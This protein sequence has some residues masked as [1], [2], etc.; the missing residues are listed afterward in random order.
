MATTIENLH[1][2]MLALRKD[3]AF[4]KHVLSEDFE[5]SEEASRGLRKARETPESEYVDLK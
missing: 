2:D 1:Q 4:I 3:V 5:L